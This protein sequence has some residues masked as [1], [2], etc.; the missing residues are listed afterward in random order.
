M[1]SIYEIYCSANDRYY[2]GSTLNPRTRWNLHKST[3]KRGVH[4]NIHL[5]NSWNKYGEEFFQFKI[6]K[7]TNGDRI[8]EEQAA[9]DMYVLKY[10]WDRIFNIGKIEDA[11]FTGC[12][13]TEEHKKYMSSKM[14][15]IN[16]PQA[17]LSW[18]LV[19]EIR[20]NYLSNPL[21]RTELGK[22]MVLLIAI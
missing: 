14:S 13:H 19:K 6:I 8:L 1:I 3:L 11:F 18:E 12:H 16:A 5:Q 15:G 17:K 2:I 21:T 10:G 4:R 22:N 7:Y 20:S 9:L